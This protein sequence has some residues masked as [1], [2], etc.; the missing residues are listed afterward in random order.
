LTK[1]NLL[2]ALL[3]CAENFGVVETLSR[4]YGSDI[5]MKVCFSR[6][7][8]EQDVDDLQ[9]SVRSHNALKRAS[10]F[11]VESVINAVA[12]GSMEKIR[13]LGRKSVSEIKTVLLQLCYDKLTEREKEQFFL[14]I[15]ENNTI[16][17][18]VQK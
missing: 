11:T 1:Q 14:Y 8:C 5:K 17:P 3:L 16:L 10:L 4:F 9:L 15:A 13:N 12:D 6:A 7:V 2:A 18:S